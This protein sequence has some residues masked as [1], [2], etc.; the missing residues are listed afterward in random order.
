MLQVLDAQGNAVR[1][2]NQLVKWTSDESVHE[3]KGLKA[4]SYLL[5][6]SVAPQGYLIATDV[7]F[8]IAADG[9]V[10]S[11]AM[12]TNGI[13]L[14]KDSLPTIKVS[15]TDITG[16]EELAGAHIQI[17]DSKGRMVT[18]WVSATDNADT[19]DVNESI[20]E[21]EGLKTGET[22]TLRETVA[23]EGYAIAT[24]TTFSIAQ[25]GKVTY[26]GTTT[27]EGVLLVKDDLL[28]PAKVALGGTKT[29][30]G[31]GLAELVEG[32]FSF[33]LKGVSDNAEDTT[34][35]TTNEEDG[36][37]SFD[38]LTFNA[39]GT[40][41]YKV[42]ETNKT[43]SGIAY[44]DV[45]YD[46]VVE[47]TDGGSGSYVAS[48][49]VRK[50]GSSKTVETSGL[51]FTNTLKTVEVAGTKTW[52]DTPED[53]ANGTRPAKVTV[54]LQSKVGEGD[55]A[56]V[57]GKIATITADDLAYTF[58]GLP[59]YEGQN[60]L[61][62]RVVD[63]V[64][65]YT[66]EGGTADKGYNL[67][68]TIIGKEVDFKPV[69]LT[70][71]KVDA[72]NNKVVVEG[73]KY[74]LVEEG[75]VA[76]EG[77]TY[78]TN[79]DGEITISFA[80]PGTW[81]LQEIEAPAGYT[82]NPKVYTIVVNQNELVNVSY[83]EGD[84]PVWSW[85]YNL[86]F[87][88]PDVTDNV[89][90]VEDAKTKVN[91]SK[92][93]V[94]GGPEVAG[95]H[96]QILDADQGIVTEWDS[97]AGKT[98]VVE[99]LTTGATYTLRETVAPDGYTI[100]T[101]TVFQLNEDGTVKTDLEAENKAKVKAGTTDTLLVEDAKTKVKVSKTD[102]AGGEEVAGAHIQIIDSKG[103]VAAEWDSTTVARE[104]EGLKTGETY[105]LKETVAPD[106]YTIASE[107]TFT[108]DETG[109]VTSTGT[110]TEGGVLLVEDALTKVTVSKRAVG[111]EDE[112]AGATIQILDESGE[113]VETAT[114]ESLEWVSGDEA[115][116]IEG[117]RTG[118]TYTLHEEVAPDGYAVA[119]DTTF[120]IDERGNVKGLS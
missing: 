111:G 89:L 85:L 34:L 33:E 63:A 119:S 82:L 35:T 12:D 41:N 28:K 37:Y 43:D 79:R 13:I 77:S 120:T 81:T 2:N 65:G 68:N 16:E 66:T 44:S 47:V 40:Y 9:K 19:T 8:Q 26:S 70:M 101:D 29:F 87:A 94:A 106:G 1:I 24:D 3:I 32:Q 116:V 51:D 11:S 104:V 22:Y 113:V 30:D 36:T 6:E 39:K 102:I 90:T 38:E 52:V 67:T 95:A 60:K 92:V 112:L 105:T 80:K 61:E 7:A 64:E 58:T 98:H 109:K 117:L 25:N 31:K 49:T 93:D 56:D 75:S 45:V 99:G 23:P 118:V 4:G 53:V 96:I 59:E 114:G 17:I 91:V 83:K 69:E 86:V 88:R 27:E 108:I 107:T 54:R 18:E 84:N 20:H 57:E 115:K 62:Y 72:D 74:C 46:V 55:W 48:T 50:S 21:V 15:K 100:A 42:Y 71:H 5:R 73:A 14:V 97:E 110:V 76:T 103:E 10:T 78:T